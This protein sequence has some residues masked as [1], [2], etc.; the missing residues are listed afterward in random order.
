MSTSLCSATQFIVHKSYVDE[1]K[2]PNQIEDRFNYNM[3][4]FS[5]NKLF[6]TSNYCKLNV[7]NKLIFK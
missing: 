2:V 1:Y 3:Q 4:S 6:G 5:L 7:H